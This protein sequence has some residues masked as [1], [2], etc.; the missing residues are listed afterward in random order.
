VS[1]GLHLQD[2][3]WVADV[4]IFDLELL[5]RTVALLVGVDILFTGHQLLRR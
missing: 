5:D 4:A 1:D 3:V 2:V